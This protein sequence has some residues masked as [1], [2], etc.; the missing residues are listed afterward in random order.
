MDVTIK[1]KDGIIEIDG[2]EWRTRESL[3]SANNIRKSNF[4][5]LRNDGHILSERLF[6]NE[7]TVFYIYRMKEVSN[8]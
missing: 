4:Y 7:K 8:G 5:N 3:M 2:I 1:R 6:L